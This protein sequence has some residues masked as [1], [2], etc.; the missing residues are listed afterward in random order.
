MAER[1]Y[2]ALLWGLALIALC[3]DQASKYSVFRWLYN[4]GAGGTYD[5]IPG[6]IE[7]L[8]QFTGRPI[9]TGTWR[10]S[11][12]NFNGS[13]MPH[14]NNGALFGLG[15][16]FGF[17]ANGFFA[18]V[19]L[20]AAAAIIIWSLRVK[21]ASDG[22]LFSA[23]GLILGGTLGNFYDRV[24]FHGVRDFINFYWFKFPVFNVADCCLVCGAG[25]LLIQAV[26]PVKKS[27]QMKPHT[28]NQENI[29]ALA[30]S[31]H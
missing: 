22:I 7:L 21:M 3:A 13:V 18:V 25:L 11:F 20:L 6:W 24:T 17:T 31:S 28:T 2:R 29:P 30:Q 12:Q 4:G 26:W 15:N 16:G 1:S 8:A 5:V 9:E 23:L 14:V 10:E 27:V 19:S